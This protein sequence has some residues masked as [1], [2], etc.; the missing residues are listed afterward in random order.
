MGEAT[1]LSGSPILSQWSL[2]NQ[3]LAMVLHEMWA[4]S[5]NAIDTRANGSKTCRMGQQ[6]YS[7][8]KKTRY[9]A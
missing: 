8:K 7:V 9:K 6:P 3:T 4:L 2:L 5:L 1:L